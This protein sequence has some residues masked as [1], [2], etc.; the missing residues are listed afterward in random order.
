VAPQNGH[1][2][3]LQEIE[4]LKQPRSYR[5]FLVDLIVVF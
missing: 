4:R 3:T 5:I 2:V 1:E